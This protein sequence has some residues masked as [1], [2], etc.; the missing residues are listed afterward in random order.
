MV[1]DFVPDFAVN[2][3]RR[4]YGILWLFAGRLADVDL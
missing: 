1:S 2:L 3:I 4:I